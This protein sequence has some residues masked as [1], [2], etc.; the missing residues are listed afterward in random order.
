MGIASHFFF[1]SIH[2]D[3]CLGIT[4]VID[5]D[6]NSILSIWFQTS[7]FLSKADCA[8]IT[9]DTKHFICAL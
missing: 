5:T 3:T 6:I 2:C 1:T 9:L 7:Q 4:T 8:L